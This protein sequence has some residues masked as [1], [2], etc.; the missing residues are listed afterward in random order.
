MPVLMP[1]VGHDSIQVEVVELRA[2][3]E[4]DLDARLEQA[5][6]EDGVLS[7]LRALGKLSEPVEERALVG[8]AMGNSLLGQ[9]PLR[10]DQSRVLEEV[11]GGSDRVA[12]GAVRDRPTNCRVAFAVLGDAPTQPVGLGH[13]VGWKERDVG[14]RRRA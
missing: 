10:R 12:R 1:Q 3:V 5:L 14:A 2:L 8:E 11:A 9:H 6:V 13:A 7:G 4:P